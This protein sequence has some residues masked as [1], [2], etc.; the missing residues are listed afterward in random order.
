MMR[1]VA[2]FYSELEACG[3]PKRYTHDLGGGTMYEYDDWLAEQCGQE[4]I[5]GWRKAMYIAARKNVVNR[6]GSY[7][8]EWDDSHLLPQAHQEFTKYF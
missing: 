5:G 8:D 7:R 3:W 1:D 6:P 2:L 4:G